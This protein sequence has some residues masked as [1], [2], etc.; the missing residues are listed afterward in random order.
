MIIECSYCKAKVD[1]KIL[2]EH[3]KSLESNEGPLAV[4]TILLE[5]PV[6]KNALVAQQEFWPTLSGRYKWTDVT[7]VWPNPEKQLDWS[8][9]IMIRT[10]LE[11]AE[12]CYR[13]GA[14]NACAVMV[15]RALESICIKHGIKVKSLKGGLKKGLEELLDRGIIDNKIYRW[16]E[17][18]RKSGNIGAHEKGKKISKEDA[19]DILDFANAICD[20]VFVLTNKF[21]NF[22]YRRQY[23]ER[24]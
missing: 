10:P 24:K 13:N 9:P 4:K 12:K 15:R 11:E 5:C 14:Y 17:E 3:E 7:R 18:L 23:M 20:Y 6:C 16:G 8:I 21:S 2:K 1:G 22:M 19:R